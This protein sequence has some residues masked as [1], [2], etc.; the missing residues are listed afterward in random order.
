MLFLVFWLEEAVYI[1]CGACYVN[2]TQSF[3]L[4]IKT[5]GVIK[6]TCLFFSS[7]NVGQNVRMILP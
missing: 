1:V 7:R 5:N 6:N 4:K 2:S 3:A